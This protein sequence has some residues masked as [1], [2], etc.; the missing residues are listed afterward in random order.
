MINIL[1][2]CAEIIREFQIS[3]FNIC[4]Q[5]S[6]IKYVAR[7]TFENSFTFGKAHTHQRNVGSSM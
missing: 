1:T 6:G 7:K 2:V 4:Y 5:K 3:F